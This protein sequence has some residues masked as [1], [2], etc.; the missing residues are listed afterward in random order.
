MRRKAYGNCHMLFITVCE[1]IYMKKLLAY[2][3]WPMQPP[4]PY[5]VFHIVLVIVGV[6]IALTAAMKL[7][8][9]SLRQHKMLLFVMAVLLLCSEL[10]KQLFHFYIMDNEHYNVWI[11]PF[12]L[13][14]LPM[15]MGL[16]FPFIKNKKIV[17]AM[18]TFFMDFT[19]LGGI[20]ALAVPEDLMQPYI[21]MTMQAFLWHFI[22]VFIGLY[23]GFSQ[24]GDTTKKGFI[25]TL[26][27]LL[28]SIILAQWINIA[29]HSYGDIS[30][31]Y[32]SPYYMTTQPVFSI[33][34]STW[35]ITISN[36]IYITLMCVG[37][38]SIH[39][40]FHVYRK[41]RSLSIR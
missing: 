5:G 21:T 8:A 16:L 31:F 36:I 1:V 26:P 29:L 24:H 41:R 28:V 9:I 19:L 37:A 2:S 17:Q 22:L 10:Y 32:I 25:K 4:T 12:Q 27:I 34:A 15:Y 6:A 18:E 7:R 3:A 20:M 38:F 13:C 14:S 35:G 23:I 39:I 11:F 40:V 30:M 33:I